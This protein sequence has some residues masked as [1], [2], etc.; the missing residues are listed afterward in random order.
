MEIEEYLG[1]LTDEE[2]LELEKQSELNALRHHRNLRLASSDWMASSDVVMPEEWRVYRQALR[3]ITDEYTN[4][5]D[6]VWPEEP[7]TGEQ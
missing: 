7:S 5:R 2:L 4:L 1:Q 3:N 6:V